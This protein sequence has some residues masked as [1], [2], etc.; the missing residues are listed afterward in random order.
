MALWYNRCSCQP[1]D[2]ADDT[3][4]E[5]VDQNGAKCRHR[6][7]FKHISDKLKARKIGDGETLYKKVK[8]RGRSDAPVLAMLQRVRLGEPALRL[9]YVERLGE[10]KLVF[11]GLCP[12]PTNAF[13]RMMGQGDECAPANQIDLSGQFTD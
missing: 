2:S 13:R 11:S 4:S 1:A 5:L 8:G 6:V 3:T 10:E 12:K 9:T 7:A